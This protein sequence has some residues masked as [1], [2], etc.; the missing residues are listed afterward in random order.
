MKG[1]KYNLKVG[2][3]YRVKDFLGEGIITST[4]EFDLKVRLEHVSGG[5]YYDSFSWFDFNN[6]VILGEVTSLIKM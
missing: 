3:R 5:N 4:S 1:N 2:D 6:K